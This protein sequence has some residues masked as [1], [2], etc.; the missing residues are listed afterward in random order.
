[1]DICVIPGTLKTLQ[2]AVSEREW[3]KGIAL[4]AA[5]LETY[6]LH[7]IKEFF[8]IDNR[9]IN[10]ESFESL[11]FNQISFMLC[12]LGVINKKTYKHM[13]QVKRMRDKLTRYRVL[14]PKL[15]R[16]QCQSLI[17]KSMY[18]LATLGAT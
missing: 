7:K 18:I 3:E 11:T 10:E 14:A 4:S 15:Y 9:D 1:M 16:K 6:G 17:R 2:L 12:A 5:Y 8:M 13:Q